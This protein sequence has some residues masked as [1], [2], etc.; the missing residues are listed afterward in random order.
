MQRNCSTF[1]ML[2]HAILLNVFSEFSSNAS[3]F[4]FFPLVIP[5]T[6]KLVFLLHYVLSKISFK[7]QMTM[8]VQYPQIHTNQLTHPFLLTSTMTMTLVLSLKMTMKTIQRS[9]NAE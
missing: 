5:L 6:F 3:G 2:R 1:V 9:R 4:S 7:K 8:K